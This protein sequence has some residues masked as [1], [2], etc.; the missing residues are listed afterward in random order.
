M[1][2]ELGVDYLVDVTA[3]REGD[4]IRLQV[5]L[6]QAVPE[7]RQLWAQAY[8]R[9]A[10]EVMALHGE[11]ARGIA[12]ALDID[13]TPE[14]E[15]RLTGTRP[16]NPETYEAYLRGMYFLNKGTAEDFQEGM[17]YLNAAVEADPGDALAWAGLAG[18][19]VTLGH[20]PAPPEGVWRLARAA[21][22]RALG[23]D[24]NLAEAHAA[25]ADIMLYGEWDWEGAEREFER[26]NA[27]NPSM[28]MNHYHYAWYLYLFGRWDEA[29]EEHELA[30]ELDPLTPL[31]SGW[32]SGMYRR[33]GRHDQALSQAH[34]VLERW[35]GIWIGQLVLGNALLDAGRYDEAIEAHEA[36]VAVNP[37][38]RGGLAL[39]Y[40]RA[41]REAKARAVLAEVEAEPL[42]GWTA[43]NRARVHAA[44][45]ELDEAFELLA[46]EPPHGWLPFIRV[47]KASASLRGDP[48]YAAL[49]ERM[50][51][52]N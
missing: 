43:L 13:L 27:L 9:D 14:E 19:Y 42:N 49:L 39:T 34:E 21:T 3:V 20:G 26:A 4:A 17:R 48:R 40:A 10:S 11:V 2:A 28:P 38:W 23:L 50:N 7:E 36:V 32:L 5:N 45:G 33:T 15:A 41:G 44:L 22:D 37:A 29:V 35:P 25:S 30:A 12:S 24:P 6:I 46:F 47:G 1:A 51:L 31:M 8:E 52:P 16:V 18:G